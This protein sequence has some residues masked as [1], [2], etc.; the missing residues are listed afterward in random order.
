MKGQT[1]S[2]VLPARQQNADFDGFRR[3]TPSVSFCSSLGFTKYNRQSGLCVSLRL[4][5]NSL[6]KLSHETTKTFLSGCQPQ[7]DWTGIW[8]SLVACYAAEWD[9]VNKHLIAD[10]GD[11]SP[12]NTCS[13]TI[14]EQKP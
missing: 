5:D 6:V 10:G 9:V 11:N 14:G 13:A 3:T 7:T 1:R 12:Q 2:R 4:D 8:H